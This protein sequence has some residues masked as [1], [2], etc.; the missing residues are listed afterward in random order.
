MFRSARPYAETAGIVEPVVCYQGA[1]VADP[2]TG[3]FLSH[4][5]IDLDLARETIA[6]LIS[7]GHTPN[8]YVDDELFVAEH[9]QHSRAYAGF[10]HLK[11]TAVGD[12]LTWID[13]APTKL[14]VV[15][16]PDELVVLRAKALAHLGDRL[17]VTTSLPTFLEFG[18]AGVSKGSAIREV[19]DRL[20]LD[21]ARVVAFGDGENDVELIE[22]A[23]FGFAIENGHPRLLAVADGICPTPHDHGVAQVMEAVVARR[24]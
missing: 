13:R 23:G 5:P 15:A 10:Q 4:R 11:V 16:D 8:V 1:V 21:V 17:F 12:L 24:A 3:V 14:V 7:A 9:T 18:R 6:F 2:V 19:C 22:E 20:G